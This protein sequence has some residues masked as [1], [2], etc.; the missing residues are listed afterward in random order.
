[1]KKTLLTFIFFASAVLFAAT[2]F[3]FKQGKC[4]IENNSEILLESGKGIKISVKPV[5]VLPKWNFCPLTNGEGIKVQR[6]AGGAAWSGKLKLK[7]EVVDFSGSA[8]EKDGILTLSFS[9]KIPETL[10][11]QDNLPL[12]IHLGGNYSGYETGLLKAG[13]S[14]SRFSANNVWSFGNRIQLAPSGLDLKTG[15]P[16][17]MSLWSD[18]AKKTWN[19]RINLPATAQNG[20]REYRGTIRVSSVRGMV[21]KLP[22]D[23]VKQ[24]REFYRRLLYPPAETQFRPAKVLGM[25]DD[26]KLNRKTLGDIENFLDARSLLFTFQDMQNHDSRKDS[27]RQT[28]LDSAW[29]ALKA[30]DIEA[31]HRRIPELRKAFRNHAS[32][33]PLVH[34]NP[35][36]WIK[37]FTQQ[38]FIKHPEGVLVYEPNPWCIVWQDGL[39][40]NAAQDDGVSIVNTSG[41]D[42]RYF[43]T[44]F[45]K[46]MPHV[47]TE[48]SWTGTTWIFPDRRVR[49][50][51]LT[52]LIDVDGTDTLKLS[53]FSSPPVRLSYIGGD[54]VERGVTL[55]KDW[56]H[57]PESIASIL[58][59]HSTVKKPEPK[60]KEGMQK[61]NPNWVGRPWLQLNLASGERLILLP[62]E[63]PVAAG[64][65]KGTFILK[66]QKKSYIGLV[67]LPANLHFRETPAVA[68]FFAGV[69]AA[70][71]SACRET[72]DG[73]KITWS[74]THDI[75]PNAWGIAPHKIAPVSPLALL[76]DIPLPGTKKFNYPTKYGMMRY[77][78]GSS[79]TLRLPD[80][81]KTLPMM[82]G[83]NVGLSEDF[84][85][86][87]KHKEDGA[88][89]IRLYLGSKG[90]PEEKFR[91][92]EEVLQYCSA[93]NLKLIVD[94][95][96]FQY[97]V[98]WTKG[99]STKEEDTERFVSLWNRLSKIASKYK[100]VVVG[101][102]LYNELGVKEGAEI[103][104]KEIALRCVDVIRKNHPEAV[105]YMTGM[106]AANPSGFFNFPE[107]GI[108]NLSIS[109][110]Y[111]TPHSFTH[112]KTATLN[113]ADSFVFYPG[114]APKIDWA[115]KKHY[116]GTC[117]EWYDRWTLAATLLPIW[118]I[119]A[120]KNIPM[121]CGEFS[122]VGYANGKAPHSAFLWTRD[123]IDLLEHCGFQW[124]L[125]NG[126]FGLGN[127]H[128]RDYI[129][130][131]WKEKKE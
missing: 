27:A 21:L 120:G 104:W 81:L 15:S 65:I 45:T 4:R 23:L 73:K 79:V 101:Y 53:G 2:E 115:G 100:N 48:R 98:P 78:E 108:Q 46:P 36:S 75:R 30:F 22:E 109:F 67:R 92:Y 68:E 76:A 117:V 8:D 12:Q 69:A 41:A 72:V 49:F 86:F 83:V 97:H 84:K 61:I 55:T 39:R 66:L 74:Y 29:N 17:T 43:E 50:S 94:P 70:Y 87:R 122:V 96:N 116:G 13:T 34:Y 124:H 28:L 7:Q 6:S 18:S 127:V 130:R 128:V 47:T 62:G 99:F 52:P 107:T 26:P 44:R 51:V 14:I 42:P 37:A 90:E 54:G 19:L 129:H 125:W 59:D 35:Y 57:E 33:M 126:G 20:I 88:D 111:Y 95:H 60:Q 3:S 121:H 31:V 1:M 114:Y 64:F 118:E 110:H 102:D 106:D 5:L 58:M 82:R 105:I 131:L 38:G 103:R 112:Q 32:W 80:S 91:R 85:I 10:K 24:K 16:Q 89:W 93:Q 71:P 25:L 63:R 11:T 40:F 9:C 77:G 123:S 119:Y 56:K 113:P